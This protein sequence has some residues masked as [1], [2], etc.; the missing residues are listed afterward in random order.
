METKKICW[1]DT[2]TTG[3]DG[4]KNDI[5]QLALILEINKKEVDRKLF[6]IQ[7]FSWANIEEEALKVNGTTVEQLKGY[8]HPT[9]VFKE[10]TQ[11]LGKYVNKFDKTD[12]FQ[13]AGFNVPFDMGFLKQ[14]FNKNNDKFF[15]SWFNYKACDP[16][17]LLYTLDSRGLIALPNYKL[18]TVCKH[19]GV[20]L[21][22]AHGAMADIEA[23]KN[24]AEFLFS[25]IN[26]DVDNLGGGYAEFCKRGR[27]A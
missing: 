23:T 11:F 24:L 9:V 20:P 25:C 21:E 10:L 6:Y 19:F 27:Q 22:G 5:I 1:I 16:L 8:P 12:K 2:E 14:F 26:I 3:I 4:Y 7:P 13:P 18:G 17:Q 15:G